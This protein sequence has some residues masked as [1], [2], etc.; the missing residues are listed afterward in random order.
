MRGVKALLVVLVSI[1]PLLCVGEP[2]AVD[3]TATVVRRNAVDDALVRAA[4][5]RIPL[6]FV[7]NTGQMDARVQYSGRGQGYGVY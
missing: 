4:A 6:L 2:N 5:G 7:P 1:S 3:D